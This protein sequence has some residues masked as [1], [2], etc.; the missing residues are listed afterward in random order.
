MLDKFTILWYFLEKERLYY[1]NMDEK[2][3]DVRKR[4]VLITAI[5]ASNRKYEKSELEKLSTDQL[6][7]LYDNVVIKG[8]K[9]E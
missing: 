2:R 6:L 5:R 3:I 8:I 1:K 9:A 7:R 4:K